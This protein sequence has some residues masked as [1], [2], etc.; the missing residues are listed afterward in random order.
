M[1]LLGSQNILKVSNNNKKIQRK[2]KFDRN[3]AKP[4]NINNK[5]CN[6]KSLNI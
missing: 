3:I 4:V 2:T 1:L 5:R 6:I